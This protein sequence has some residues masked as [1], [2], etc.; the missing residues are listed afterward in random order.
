[1]SSDDE[2]QP[3][4]EVSELFLAAIERND[5]EAVQQA[6]RNGVYVDAYLWRETP[7]MHAT[8]RGH[9][10]IVRILL[11]A[12]ATTQY[13]DPYDERTAIQYACCNGQLGIVQM[14]IDHESTLLDVAPVGWTPLM[15]A[16]DKEETEICRFLVDRG[17]NIHA[18]SSAEHGRRGE[19]ALMLAVQKHS[20]D[21]VRMLLSAG[22]NVDDCD[23]DGKTVCHYAVENFSADV[24]IA[25]LMHNADMCH[26]NSKANDLLI[27]LMFSRGSSHNNFNVPILRIRDDLGR[28]PIHVACQCNFSVGVLAVLVEHDPAT[29]HM[30]D[31]AGNLPLHVWCRCYS[32]TTEYFSALKYLVEHGGGIGTL[33]AR[34]GDGALPLHV[35]CGAS[36]I[37]TASLALPVVQ[38]LIQ[39]FRGSVAMSTNSALY[40]FMIAA[41]NATLSVVYEIVRANPVLAIPQ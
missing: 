35:L 29:L 16:C 31:F 12:G 24:M 17:C 6:L 33:A 8:K 36:T 28:S 15:Y 38:Y 19:N 14:L 26:W 23:K 11:D 7:L 4:S 25:L 21:I 27:R 3:L 32:D 41:N 5:S 39:S 20:L 2:E 1:M 40:P 34:N 9:E 37:A 10:Q 18:K 13:T 30:A 22:A